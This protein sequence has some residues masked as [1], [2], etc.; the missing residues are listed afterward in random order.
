MIFYVVIALCFVL[1][2]L[3][4]GSVLSFF[5]MERALPDLFL[6]LVVSLGFILGERKGGIFKL[7]FGL[8]QDVIFGSALGF[9]PWPR[10]SSV[11][12]R[13]ARRELY[14]DQL[15]AP[16]LLVLPLRSPTN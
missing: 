11:T 14:Q 9:S 8:L 2:L 10:C 13:P 3:L 6:V 12:G 15:P 1:S 5:I 16:V 4:E 7:G